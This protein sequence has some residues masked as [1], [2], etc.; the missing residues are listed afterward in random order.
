[1]ISN[2][3]TSR[4]CIQ[5]PVV[6]LLSIPIIIALVL[7]IKKTFIKFRND[8]EGIENNKQNKPKRKLMIVTRSFM[9][10][11]LMIALASPYIEKKVTSA[12]DPRLKILSDNSSSFDLFEQDIAKDLKKRLE[13]HIPVDLGY[14]ADKKDSAIGDGILANMEG[15]DNLLIIT[16]GNNNRGKD[17]GDIMLFASMMNTTVSTLD[18]S[19]VKKDASV[20]ISGPSE[21]IVD[22]E[23]DF[24]VD[25]TDIGDVDHDLEVEVDGKKAALDENRFSL[26][27]SEGYH[28]IT[29]RI[30]A[31]DHFSQNNI[32]Y[33]SVKVVPRPK[34]L[35]VGEGSSPLEE[36]L[37]EIYDLHSL[38][39]IPSD[40]G[41]YSAIILDD[42]HAD[43][44]KNRIETLSQY[45]ADSGNGMVVVGGKDSY[46]KGFYKS[47]LF[48]NMLPVQVGRAE[49][50]GESDTNIVV[51]ID[52]SESTGIT[53]G[54]GSSNK[55][56]DVEK[57]LA[58]SVI[59]DIRIDDNVAVV[60][61]NH[62]SHL[63]SPLMPLRENADVYDKVS[64]LIDSGGTLVS[65][66]LRRAETLLEDAKGSKN[67]ILISDG[68]T[69]MSADALSLAGILSKKGI[70]IFTV[71]V[72]DT[73]DR[74]FMQTLARQGKGLY[75]E[76]SESQNLKIFFG[77]PEPDEDKDRFSIV[78]LDS[79]HFITRD[80]SLGASITGFN[81]VAAKPS[82][83]LLA[84]TAGGSP[85][86]AVWRYGIGRV[87]SLSTDSGSSWSGSL[88]TKENSR[89]ISRTVNWAIGDLSRNKAYDVSAKDTFVDKAT[90]VNVVSDEIPDTEDLDFAKIDTN[91]YSAEFASDKPGFHD[92]LDA[93]VA[94]NHD[95]EYFDLGMDPELKDLVTSSGGK[96]FDPSNTDAIIEG[97]KTMSKRIKTETAYYRWPFALA[98]LLVL[99]IEIAIRRYHENKSIRIGKQGA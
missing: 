83:R 55:K 91:L 47:S 46:D 77:E 84:S 3:C 23:N 10:I 24:Y 65:S 37:S 6:A 52:I 16:D 59:R 22:T 94:V 86:L 33:K 44:V 76:P 87:A 12:G 61:F 42:L 53:F 36:V 92:V 85:I 66:G 2:L 89:L 1:M 30:Y 17:L 40:I 18:I 31:E 70:K 71:G 50:K 14:I 21:V 68:I 51:V 54:G 5:Y 32:F 11:F 96:L 75:F 28:K 35:L 74:S 56:L 99:I 64:S 90:D 34:V 80:L 29:A 97:V 62:Y 81:Y 95:D 13:R 8:K 67:I 4:F 45:T 25:V 88:Y 15:D 82:A 63:V 72:G 78:V 73:T 27:L 60:A 43:D 57:A 19:P 38:D 20:R 49:S 7:I 58:L 93:V 69:Q 79:G 39:N 41:S 26:K 48:E 9:I 98:A